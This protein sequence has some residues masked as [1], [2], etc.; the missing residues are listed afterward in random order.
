VKFQTFQQQIADRFTDQRMV[1]RLTELFGA[2]ALL[3]ATIGIYGVIAYS[4]ARQ[5]SEIGIRMALGARR[6]SVVVMVL[7]DA[8]LQIALGLALGIPTAYFCVRYVES[9][10]Y[11]IKGLTPVVLF[12]AVAALVLAAVIAALIPARRAASIDPAEVLRME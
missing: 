11:D 10:L 2:L 12:I 3:L 6:V 4:V 1:A 9:Q 5:T 7:R 8:M